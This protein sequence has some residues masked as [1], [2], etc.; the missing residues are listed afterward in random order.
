MNRSD[1]ESRLARLEAVEEI[2]K[3]K[4]LYCAYC[5]DKYNPDKLATLFTQDAV[6][7]AAHRGR[8]EGREAIREFFAGISKKISFAA[9]LVMNDMI[10]VNGE[11]A[12]GRWRMVMAS[13]E[14]FDGVPRAVWSLG[15]Y[16]EVYVR[17]AGGWRIK[18]LHVAIDLLDPVSGRWTRR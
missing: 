12:T 16:D 7:H 1:L 13:M 8:L 14:T 3:L 5:D 9:H 2:R 17:E 18:S 4:A 6:W 11:R 15:D 10:E